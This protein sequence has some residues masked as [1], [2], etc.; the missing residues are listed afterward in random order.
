MNPMVAVLRITHIKRT[1]VHSYF[2]DRIAFYNLY[3]STIMQS[4]EILIVAIITVVAVVIGACAIVA[5]NNSSG[6]EEPSI[7]P[8][9]IGII[10]AMESEVKTIKEAMTIDYTEEIAS[11]KFCVGKLYDKDVVVV[12]CG[13]GKV[14]AGLCAHTLINLYNVKYV[15]NT[16]VAGSL[17]NRL[18]IGDY[19]VSEDAVQHDFDVSPI[20][21]QK[22]E[23]PYTGLY[24]F[25]ADEGLREKA[26]NAISDCIGAVFLEGRVCSGDQFISSSEQKEKITEE[27]G[28]LCCEMEGG[29]IA[30]VC[31]LNNTPFVIIRAVSDKADGSATE[32]FEEFSKRIAIQCSKM[33]LYMIEHFDDEPDAARSL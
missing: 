20:G 13:M 26:R 11:M 24:A 32:D 33:I 3:I 31:Y 6:S 14:N 8:E 12:Q 1:V 18:N 7:E 27:F 30:H 16:G 21:Y 22:G 19:V 28:G 5:I 23:I 15:I 10:G 29:A 9:R 17:D 4:K 2:V 25:K